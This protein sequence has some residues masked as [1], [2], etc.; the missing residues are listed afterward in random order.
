LSSRSAGLETAG[1]DIISTTALFGPV[2]AGSIED[3]AIAVRA[4]LYLLAR[5]KFW[6]F[7]AS[8]APAGHR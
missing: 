3:T 2:A 1:V 4:W 6:L 8:R 5:R 7:S